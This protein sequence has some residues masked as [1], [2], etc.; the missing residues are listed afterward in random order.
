MKA[1]VFV[2]MLLLVIA[3]SSVEC[4]AECPLVSEDYLF[5]TKAVPPAEQDKDAIYV[6]ETGGIAKSYDIESCTA[7]SVSIT[8]DAAQ[9]T[10]ALGAATVSFKIYSGKNMI[11]TKTFP[12]DNILLAWQDLRNSA[13]MK[14]Y[15]A[16]IKLS[17]K[18]T[19]TKLDIKAVAGNWAVVIN[20]LEVTFQ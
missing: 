10:Q 8:F 17:G 11:G 12:I 13:K 19:P 3:A 16:N 4:Y 5:I 1:K 9:Y 20:N 18:G 15:T 6:S 14:K 2:L 7:T